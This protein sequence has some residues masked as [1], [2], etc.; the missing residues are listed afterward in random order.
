MRIRD[1]SASASPSTES[2]FAIRTATEAELSDPIQFGNY[3]LE[4]LAVVGLV[5]TT[6]WVIAHSV[7]DPDLWGH[8]RFG[9]DIL[10]LGYIP[11]WDSCSFLA[12][13]PWVNHEWLAEVVMGSCLSSGGKV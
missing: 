4:I 1:L 12:D 7:V 5:T 8:I 10:T 6:L 11:R 3:V 2:R 13:R 9:Q